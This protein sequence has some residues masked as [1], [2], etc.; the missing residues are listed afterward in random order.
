MTKDEILVYSFKQLPELQTYPGETFT[1]ILNNKPGII[2]IQLSNHDLNIGRF[3][4]DAPL[5]IT[6]KK[7]LYYPQHGLSCKTTWQME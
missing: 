3:D 2:P 6:F 1:V 5:C 4:A 7:H